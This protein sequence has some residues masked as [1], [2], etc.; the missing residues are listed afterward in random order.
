MG[1]KCITEE[2]MYEV[3]GGGRPKELVYRGQHPE[4]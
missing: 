1:N 3:P 4:G 2:V